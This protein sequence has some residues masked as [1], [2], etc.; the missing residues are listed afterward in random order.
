MF[1]ELKTASWS[2]K[3]EE[4]CLVRIR[5]KGLHNHLFLLDGVS[6]VRNARDRSSRDLPV[7]L[8]RF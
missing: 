6:V 4:F 1:S 3:A 2:E 7:S 5:T 8:L